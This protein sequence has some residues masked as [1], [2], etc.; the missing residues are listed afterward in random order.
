MALGERPLRMKDISRYCGAALQEKE[1]RTAAIGTVGGRVIVSFE[2]RLR[3]C[4][5]G[6]PATKR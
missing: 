1:Q 5:A 2:Y 6:G 3:H 4:A